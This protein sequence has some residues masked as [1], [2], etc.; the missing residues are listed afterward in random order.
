MRYVANGLDRTVSLL[1]L[2]T[3]R[4]VQPTLPVRPNPWRV[5]SGDGDRVL[6]LSVGGMARGT[7]TYVAPAGDTWQV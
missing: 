6:M 5:V 3:G 1:V 7:R 2:R 4:S